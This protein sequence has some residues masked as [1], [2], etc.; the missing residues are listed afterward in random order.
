MSLNTEIDKKLNS[1][2][3][4][5]LSEALDGDTV[6]PKKD[7]AVLGL[8]SIS[9]FNFTTQLKEIIPTVPLTIF[10]ECK[11]INELKDYLYTNHE[12]EITE[13]FQNN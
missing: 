6:S 13:Y 1:F 12:E 9:V 2:L 3:I 10:L 4:G 11:N 8:D 7:F 5:C